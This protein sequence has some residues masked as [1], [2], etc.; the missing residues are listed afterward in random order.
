MAAF[1]VGPDGEL[2]A[3]LDVAAQARVGS[4]MCVGHQ[5]TVQRV[6][7]LVN[8][9][10]VDAF[11]ASGVVDILHVGVVQVMMAAKGRK[12]YFKLDIL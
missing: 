10:T 9:R 5:V 7:G 3:G 12:Q 4:Q 11:Q 6:P 1:K 8:I 2:G